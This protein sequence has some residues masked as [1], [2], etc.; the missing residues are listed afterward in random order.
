MDVIC[1]IGYDNIYWRIGPTKPY[2][3]VSQTVKH[4]QEEAAGRATKDKADPNN[5]IEKYKVYYYK[6]NAVLHMFG[7][8]YRVQKLILCIPNSVRSN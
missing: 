1:S 6:K 2:I 8:I 7:F 4:N 5:R 3:R